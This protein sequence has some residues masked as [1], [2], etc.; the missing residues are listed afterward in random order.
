MLQRLFKSDWSVTQTGK[1]ILLISGREYMDGK[2][3]DELM[4]EGLTELQ[5]CQPENLRWTRCLLFSRGSS[6]SLFIWL[7][8]G[9]LLSWSDNLIPNIAG[10][11]EASSSGW[12]HSV[13]SSNRFLSI[14]KTLSYNSQDCAV[15]FT[16]WKEVECQNFLTEMYYKG[17]DKL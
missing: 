14:S 10:G 2:T 16:P 8:D 17:T 1:I 3:G 4:T 12:K 13:R 5:A 6:W 11:E 15:S 9:V 7:S